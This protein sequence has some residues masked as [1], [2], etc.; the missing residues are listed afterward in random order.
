[1]KIRLSARGLFSIGFAILVVTN[2]IVLSGVAFNRSGEPDAR[3]TLTERELPLPYQVHKENS[4]LALQ[5]RWRALGKTGGDARSSYGRSPAWLDAEK[6]KALGFPIGDYVTTGGDSGVRKK[7]LPKEVFIVLENNGQ[8]YREALKQAEQA[9]ESA[10]EAFKLK[11]GDQRRRNQH[12]AAARALKRERF[13]ETRLFAIDAGLDAKKLR[14]QYPDRSRFIITRGLVKPRFNYNKDNTEVD[15]YIS[16]LSV[17]SINVPRQQ[18]PIF[19]LIL[20]QKK[21]HAS[22]FQPPRYEVKLMYGRRWEPWILSA[23]PLRD[24]S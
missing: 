4:G 17:A 7:T 5:L 13:A 23:R 20:T 2:A 8:H 22:D 9:L 21:S 19:D 16:T 24:P 12:K 6:L 3:L 1:M 14:A 10:E 15:G 11:P 18:R